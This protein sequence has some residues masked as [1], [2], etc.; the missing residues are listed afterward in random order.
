MG[1]KD[2]NLLNLMALSAEFVPFCAREDGDVN[3]EDDMLFLG[4]CVNENKYLVVYC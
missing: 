4:F 1:E 3:G 2:P